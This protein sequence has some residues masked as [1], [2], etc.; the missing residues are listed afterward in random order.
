MN[1]Y[2]PYFL[3]LSEQQKRQAVEAVV[4]SSDEPLSLE[5][6]FEVLFEKDE[7]DRILIKSNKIDK[8]LTHKEFASII[9]DEYSWSESHLKDII[10]SL[11]EEFEVENRA[12]RIVDY[13]GGY[14]FTT[15]AEFGQM[16]ARFY[17]RKSKKKL[18]KAALEV[19]AIIAYK[20]PISKPGVEEIR[21]VNSNEVVNSLLEK[22]LIK[23]AGRSKSLGK[24]LLYATSDNFLKLFA[25]NSIDDLPKLKEIEE[26]ATPKEIP[27][28]QVTID[29]ED[30]DNSDELVKNVNEN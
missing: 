1:N 29:L 15:K 2:Y 30:I 14:S 7:F 18:S 6:L 4:F 3:T 5:L 23:I 22:D 16:V 17:N 21:G 20:Q 11:N 27:D 8:P 10:R 12:I 19:L 25:L 13:A 24:S 26:L 28:N 9:F